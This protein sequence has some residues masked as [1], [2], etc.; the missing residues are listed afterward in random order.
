[1]P[2]PGALTTLGAGLSESP[3]PGPAGPP[4]SQEEGWGLGVSGCSDIQPYVAKRKNA[5]AAGGGRIGAA[6]CPKFY[7]QFAE[8]TKIPP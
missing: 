2:V 5:L 6:A 7:F 3:S 4:S 1:V 8:K